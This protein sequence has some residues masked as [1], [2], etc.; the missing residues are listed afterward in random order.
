MSDGKSHGEMITE[1][2]KAHADMV[3]AFGEYCLQEG[4]DLSTMDDDKIRSFL[5][6]LT[7][8]FR[9][10]H[11][12]YVTT[13][14]LI[15]ALGCYPETRILIENEED[16][17]Y[18]DITPEHI[19]YMLVELNADLEEHQ[20]GPHIESGYGE[21]VLVISRKRINSNPPKPLH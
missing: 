11:N 3:E 18:M 21:T 7:R 4:K 16:G 13:T 15:D 17:S 10:K 9:R 6:D 12:K 19:G 1:R 5:M 20:Q 8:A 14:E 2:A